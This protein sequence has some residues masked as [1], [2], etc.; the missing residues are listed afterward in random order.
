MLTTAVIVDGIGGFLK[1]R[2]RKKIL[3]ERTV[4]LLRTSELRRTLKEMYLTRNFAGTLLTAMRHA[5]EC[6]HF[7]FDMDTTYTT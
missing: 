4:L 5:R 7:V 2:V 1:L 3:K 6:V